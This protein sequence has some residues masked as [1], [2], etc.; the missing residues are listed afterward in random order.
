[1]FQVPMSSPQMTRMLGFCCAK[2]ATARM[3]SRQ[4]KTSFLIIIMMISVNYFRGNTI[5]F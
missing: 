2:T 5:K 1:M 4:E 3:L